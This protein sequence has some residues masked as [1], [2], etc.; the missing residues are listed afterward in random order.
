MK[1]LVVTLMTRHGGEQD[2]LKS[3][4]TV[5]SYLTLVISKIQPFSNTSLSNG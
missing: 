5:T 4:S 2:K 1:I 3:I